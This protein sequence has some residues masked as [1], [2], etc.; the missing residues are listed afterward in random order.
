MSGMPTDSTL[1]HFVRAE[2]EKELA[3]DGHPSSGEEFFSSSGED[4][5]RSGRSTTPN[6]DDEYR[7]GLLLDLCASSAAVHSDRDF[8]KTCRRVTLRQ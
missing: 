4:D 2:E 5:D 8:D 3:Y 1:H 6:T 7:A